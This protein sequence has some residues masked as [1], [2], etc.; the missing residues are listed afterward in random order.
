MSKYANFSKS[1]NK[2]QGECGGSSSKGCTLEF[3]NGRSIPLR[4]NINSGGR[5]DPTKFFVHLPHKLT[6]TSAGYYTLGG[7]K[8]QPAMAII[9]P[10]APVYKINNKL[11][12]GIIAIVGAFSTENSKEIKEKAEKKKNIQDWLGVGGKLEASGMSQVFIPIMLSDTS[13]KG[14]EPMENIIRSFIDKHQD[15]ADGAIDTGLDF[16]LDDF[17]STSPAFYAARNFDMP[18]AYL[19]LSSSVNISTEVYMMF[20]KKIFPETQQM[21]DEKLLNMTKELYQQ[22]F[23]NLASKDLKRMRNQTQKVTFYYNEGGSG[24][25]V[26]SGM[27]SRPQGSR[28]KSNRGGGRLGT[29]SYNISNSG[30]GDIYIDCQPVNRNE[31]EMRVKMEGYKITSKFD[32]FDKTK[33]KNFFKNPWVQGFILFLVILL[34]FYI[35]KMLMAKGKSQGKADLQKGGSKISSDSS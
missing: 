31:E 11:V 6:D 7:I 16:N 22:D 23:T 27:A 35:V 14:S 8:Y 24:S 28:E 17:V 9:Q 32:L 19:D 4:M 10:F 15:G 33:I 20:L 1:D 13:S 30:P 12:Y 26:G 2:Y 29:S 18:F 34:L 21:S 25:T 5:T 3:G